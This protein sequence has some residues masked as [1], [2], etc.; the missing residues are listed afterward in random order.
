MYMYCIFFLKEV[1]FGVSCLNLNLVIVDGLLL[2]IGILWSGIMIKLIL[3]DWC[4]KGMKR[5]CLMN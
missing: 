5:E 3:L 2:G 1:Y 4:F